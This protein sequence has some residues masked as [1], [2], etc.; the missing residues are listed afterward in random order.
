[1]NFTRLAVIGLCLTLQAFAGMPDEDPIAAKYVGRF[2]NARV[3]HFEDLVRYKDPRATHD[4]NQTMG[5]WMSC[6]T[7]DLSRGNF[8]SSYRRYDFVQRTPDI[9]EDANY[10]YII[11]HGELQANGNFDLRT[12]LDA[13]KTL[14]TRIYATV[15]VEADGQLIIE[16]AIVPLKEAKLSGYE[17]V[18]SVALNPTAKIIS[19][20]V[21]DPKNLIY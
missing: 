4:R 17:L 6:H 14:P 20:G 18:S 10:E 19:Y 12:D 11:N 16:T 13:T 8:I 7:R 15:R 21:C 3:P 1:M 5:I 2:A 9:I